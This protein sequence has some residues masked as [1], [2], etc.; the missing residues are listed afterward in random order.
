[1]ILSVFRVAEYVQ[2]GRGYLLRRGLWLYISDGALMASVMLLFN[3]VHPNKVGAPSTH[4]KVAE[5][6]EVGLADAS[7]DGVVLYSS[8][9]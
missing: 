4:D 6:E 2:G 3:V 9:F 5:T 8:I 7:I 1:M